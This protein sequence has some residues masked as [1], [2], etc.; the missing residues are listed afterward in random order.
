[1]TSAISEPIYILCG[2][3]LCYIRTYIHPVWSWP[4]LYQNLYT[5]CVVMTS[6]I[7]QPIYILCG[8]DLCY[9]RTY[10]HPVWS[11]PL[12]Y[13]NQYT[14]C[15]LMT[16]WNWET[17]V[18]L[19]ADLHQHNTFRNYLFMQTL[20]KIKKICQRHGGFKNNE[21][22]VCGLGG[23]GV[24]V[25]VVAGCMVGLAGG[26]VGGG[27][28]EGDI[29]LWTE[30]L[31]ACGTISS[32]STGP[33]SRCPPLLSP[34]TESTTLSWTESSQPPTAFNF[35]PALCTSTGSVH[36]YPYWHWHASVDSPRTEGL[37][38]Q[39]ARNSRVD[40]RPT[41]KDFCVTAPDT[42]GLLCDRARNSEGLPACHRA[43]NWRTPA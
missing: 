32:G 18:G 13:H 4:L 42:K 15:V 21:N 24:C 1:M 12:L 28:W 41:L 14:S 16:S 43:W 23:G 31:Q 39:R 10:I 25:C 3:D 27:G 8:H 2:H 7:S 38:C 33:V 22:G 35:L 17:F 9:I 26:W 40:A 37:P 19:G 36:H 29:A 30:S 5:S 34:L 11:W 20:Q 6:A